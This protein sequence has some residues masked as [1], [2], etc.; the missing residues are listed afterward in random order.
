MK[1]SVEQQ[2]EIKKT[3]RNWLLTSVNPSLGTFSILPNQL[4][5]SFI[6]M[7]L[8]RRVLSQLTPV[9]RFFAETIK[10]FNKTSAGQD[11]LRQFLLSRFKSLAQNPLVDIKDLNNLPIPAALGAIERA[12]DIKSQVR[13]S[14]A[15]RIKTNVYEIAVNIICCLMAVSGRGRGGSSSYCKIKL[16]AKEVKACRGIFICLCAASSYGFYYTMNSGNDDENTNYLNFVS[17]GTMGVTGVTLLIDSVQSLFSYCRQREV[18]EVKSQLSFLR[19]MHFSIN[20]D[21]ETSET[22]SSHYVRLD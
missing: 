1:K 2:I 14:R 10:E 9:S 6:L 4:F 13:I 20:D 15:Q 11:N 7:H 22:T 16:S 21:S 8:D 5:M 3:H 17:A 18:N 12:I 19:N